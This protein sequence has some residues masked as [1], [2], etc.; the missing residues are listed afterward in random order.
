MHHE[1]WPEYVLRVTAG[2]PRR[3]I[4]QAADVNVSGVSR[5]ITGASRPSAEKVVAFARGLKLNPIEALVAAD[6]LDAAEISGVVE[7]VRPRAELSDEEL[8][9]EI[10]SRLAERH[11]GSRSADGVVLPDQVKERPVPFGWAGRSGEQSRMSGNQ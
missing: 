8:L 10:A 1:T 5:W 11:E 4:A 9:E 6:Y 3:D 2:V 7:V